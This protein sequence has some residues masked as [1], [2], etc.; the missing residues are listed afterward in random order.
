MS[1]G[2]SI[3]GEGGGGD[4]RTA[5]VGVV[6]RAEGE[7]GEGSIELPAL[8]ASAKY[9]VV[10]SPGVIGAVGAAWGECASE[11]RG[12]EGGDAGCDSEFLCRLIEGE[13]SLTELLEEGLLGF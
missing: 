6:F 7:G 1:E 11:F 5:Q 3:L 8:N 10:V 2:G 13:E 4:E 9:E 12:G